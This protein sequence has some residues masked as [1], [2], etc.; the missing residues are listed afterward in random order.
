[1]PKIMPRV[2]RD[3]PAREIAPVET[4]AYRITAP[5][6]IE[7]E[8]RTIKSIPHG[9]VLLRT[10]WAGICA[11]D[12]RYVAGRRPPEVLQKKLPLVPGHE[13]V[14][15]V[16]EASSDVKEVSSGDKV[17]VVPNIPCYVQDPEK[18]PG[19]EQAC[20]ACRPGGTGENYC[21]DVAFL[22]STVDGVMQTHM[23][24]PAWGLVKLPD[25]MPLDVGVL[26]EPV[27]VAIRAARQVEI[28]SDGRVCVLGA[29]VV[30]YVMALT[31]SKAF[32][33]GKD[34][35]TVTDV[36]APRLE[37]VKPFANTSLAS[38]ANGPCNEEDSSALVFE[39]AGGQAAHRTIPQA[40]NLLGPGG[41]CMLLGV[42]EGPVPIPT[43]LILDKGLT[44]KG[45]TRSIKEDVEEAV[46][47]LRDADFREA[48]AKVIYPET[49]PAD[50]AESI[51]RAA[52]IADD[53]AS[54]GRVLLRW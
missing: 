36:R 43:R 39:C 30:G 17:A 16:I 26:A 24:H 53:P 41:V 25:D 22:G 33:V 18:Y 9:T 14:A 27:S 1:L 44:L 45:T 3:A 49:Y 8:P 40:I 46:G 50:S 32:G 11:A 20:R 13:G 51:I 37:A 34:R 54:Y 47:L 48:I 23:L 35:L 4:V 6:T 15:E 19:I 31:L 52:R 42:T 12:L 10:L 7:A 29:G 2:Q 28:P 5:W 21:L 38:N